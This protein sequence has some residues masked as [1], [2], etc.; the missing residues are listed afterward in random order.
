MVH[1]KECATKISL[2]ITLNLLNIFLNRQ[3]VHFLDP[4]NQNDDLLHEIL[5][6]MNN[7]TV[8]MCELG[9]ALKITQVTVQI[10]E[11][12]FYRVDLQIKEQN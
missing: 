9:T 11:V 6:A 8:I 4:H 3:Q 12:I 1:T 10:H 2:P 7:E 5:E